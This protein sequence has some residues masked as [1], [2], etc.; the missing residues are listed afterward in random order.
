MRPKAL[1]TGATGFLGRTVT[2]LLLFRGWEVVVAHRQLSSQ[3]R[4]QE[5]AQHGATAAPFSSHSQLRRIAKTENPDA[6]F[7]LAA[8]QARPHDADD[9]DMFVEANIAMGT[10][11]MDALSDTN[12][13]FVNAMSYF[14]FRDGATS[15]HS[16]Y[17]A[18]K[19][20]F[21][22]MS[23][24]YREVVGMD[25]RNVVLYD[26]FGPHDSRDKLINQ[27]VA[28]LKNDR[29]I[30]MGPST[31]RINLLYIEDVAKGLVAASLPDNSGEMLTVKSPQTVQVAEIVKE[32]ERISGRSIK[33]T[34][35][36]TPPSDLVDRSGAWP[37]PKGWHPE[38]SLADGL[39]LTYGEFV[40]ASQP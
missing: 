10:H 22:E 5:F 40:S 13:V 36:T 2:N 16:L 25:I 11:L 19:Q 28:A 4:V 23:R 17:S 20:A 1:V 39:E 37:T 31:Q 38:I 30:A 8:H 9:I 3:R 21:L 24:Y 12:C 26:N 29:P 15:A 14:Q 32:L 18:T 27:L 33:A 35:G 7:H 6:I 34:F